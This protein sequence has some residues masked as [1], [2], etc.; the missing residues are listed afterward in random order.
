MR[1]DRRQPEV[2]GRL[3]RRV[4]PRLAALVPLEGRHQRERLPA[5]GALEEAGRL[6][7]D[8][9]AAVRGHHVGDLGQL[10]LAVA[11]G[12]AEPRAGVLPRLAQVGAAPD[13]RAV[14]LAGGGG[15]DR[16][17]VAVQDGVVDGPVLAVRAA[18]VPVAPVLALQHEQ[19]L[20]GS[21]EE[22]AVRHSVHL[23]LDDRPSVDRIRTAKS[24]VCARMRAA[25]GA[26]V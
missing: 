16:A 24:S 7:A 23:R 2:A 1:D 13:R 8:E 19:A 3:L 5:V 12:I 25:P 21:D 6:G 11:V 4:V 17:R 18:H 26:P 15:E 22:H 14:P 20:A 10:Q 9:Q